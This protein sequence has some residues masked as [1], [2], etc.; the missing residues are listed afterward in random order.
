[1]TERTCIRGDTLRF[2]VS[3]GGST[4]GW[5]PRLELR[6]HPADATPLGSLQAGDGITANGSDW[7][8]ELSESVTR[9]L[10]EPGRP[11]LVYYQLRASQAAPGD[12]KTLESG[13]IRIGRDTTRMSD[14]FADA[15]G[16]V[17]NT[18]GDQGEF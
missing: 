18:L 13:V 6:K 12:T 4:T 11:G 8:I 7:D 2:T 3:N 17:P 10:S 14:G 9:S 15:T 16:A 1:M 5:T